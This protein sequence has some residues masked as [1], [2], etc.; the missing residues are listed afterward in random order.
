MTSAHFRLE[1]LFTNLATR[2]ADNN[3]PPFVPGDA[4]LSI[5]TLTKQLEDLAVPEQAAEKELHAEL[6]HQMRLHRMNDQH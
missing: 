4:A 1:S 5:T 3:R 2:L 6:N